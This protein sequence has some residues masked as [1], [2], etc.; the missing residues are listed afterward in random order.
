[1]KQLGRLN[2]LEILSLGGKLI[3]DEACNDLANM[4]SL[5]FVE[6]HDTAITEAGLEILTKAFGEQSNHTN[7]IDSTIHLQRK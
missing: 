1:M 7:R 3:S 4:K 6:L 5:L 2:N